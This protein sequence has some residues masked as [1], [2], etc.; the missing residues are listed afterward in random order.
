M[1][2][3]YSTSK[4]GEIPVPL[5]PLGPLGRGQVVFFLTVQ[6]TWAMEDRGW[7]LQP[8]IWGMTIQKSQLLPEVQWPGWP[9]AT[10]VTK[11]I[12]SRA[13]NLHR[14]KGRKVCF[15]RGL[16]VAYAAWDSHG[17]SF[18][19]DI[20]LCK[21]QAA[22]SRRFFWPTHW[23]PRYLTIHKGFIAWLQLELERKKCGHTCHNWHCTPRNWHGGKSTYIIWTASFTSMWICV[24]A[25]QLILFRPLEIF[26]FARINPPSIANMS[27]WHFGPTH[28]PYKPIQIWCSSCV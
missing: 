4:Q 3:I 5:G 8:A 16:H 6:V 2:V 15:T 25:R 26:S 28:G 17:L 19:G 20:G 21:A 9:I 12:K 14:F 7:V 22:L 24:L 1:Y 23:P 18:Y 27:C 10:S 11:N 13:E